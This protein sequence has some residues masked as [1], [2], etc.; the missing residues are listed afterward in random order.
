MVIHH[1]DAL[2]HIMVK[3][4]W[5]LTSY[6]NSFNQHTHILKQA[7]VACCGVGWTHLLLLDSAKCLNHLV[8]CTAKLLNT[9]KECVDTK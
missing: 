3:P 2:I 5:S 6:T 4:E 7:T 9:D 8:E 1:R